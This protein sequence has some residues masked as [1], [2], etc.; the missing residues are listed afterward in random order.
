[1]SSAW[2][3]EIAP[4]ARRA[5]RKLDRTAAARILA[6]LETLV[7]ERDD[8]RSTG[9]A[10]AGELAGFWRY[11]VGA[12]RLICRIEDERLVVLILEVGHRRE[13]YR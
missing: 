1:M 12:Y 10:L 4:R 9:K 3:I 6:W 8:P 2:T 13:V 11:R 5:F 7:E